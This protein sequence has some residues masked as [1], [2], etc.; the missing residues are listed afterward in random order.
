MLTPVSTTTTYFEGVG[1]LS[2]RMKES[3]G[4]TNRAIVNYSPWI[5]Y[6]EVGDD[7]GRL[8]TGDM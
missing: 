1:T 6:S 5:L 3:E 7:W 2:D 8:G 4:P